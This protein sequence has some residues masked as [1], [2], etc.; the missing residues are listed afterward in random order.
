MPGNKKQKVVNERGEEGAV[1]SDEEKS[2]YVPSSQP[3]SVI[4]FSKS[5]C[6]SSSHIKGSPILKSMKIILPILSEDLSSLKSMIGTFNYIEAEEMDES[7]ATLMP[8]MDEATQIADKPTFKEA[9]ELKDTVSN[10][11]GPI[12]PESKSKDIIKLGDNAIF[13]LYESGR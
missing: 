6:R 10:F 3:V 12:I 11:G 1:V 13:S 2:T 8:S 9:K 4:S 5:F 7:V